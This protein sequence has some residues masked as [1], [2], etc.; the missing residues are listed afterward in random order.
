VRQQQEHARVEREE[1]RHA[2]TADGA[3]LTDPQFE[4]L[5]AAITAEQKRIDKEFSAMSLKQ[6][7]QRRPDTSRRLADVAAP[8]LNPQQLDRYRRYLQQQQDEMTAMD[9]MVAFPDD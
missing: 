1:L 2:I 3:P 5:D 7:T 4:L 8:H 9:A 6:Q